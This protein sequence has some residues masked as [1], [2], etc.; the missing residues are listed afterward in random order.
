[1]LV[2]SP[3]GSPLGDV[4][5]T[6]RVLKEGL[7][8][9]PVLSFSVPEELQVLMPLEGAVETAFGRFILKEKKKAGDYY[10]VV[11][12]PDTDSLVADLVTKAYITMT[13]TEM[14]ADLLDG[15]GWTIQSASTEK[16]TVTLNEQTRYEGLLA[17][18]NRF[19][20]E[21]RWDIVNKVVQIEPRIGREN[22]GLY[23]HDQVNMRD[24]S[25]AADSYDL[26]T[27][28]IPRG[29]AGIGIESINGGIPYLEN[30]SYTNK[31]KVA[32][33]PDERY[34]VIENLKADA[35][36]ILDE[37]SKIRQAFQADVSDLAAAYPSIWGVLDFQIGDTVSLVS[38]RAGVDQQQRIIER[39]RY[40]D[41]LDGDSITIANTL[42]DY[43]TDARDD[44][45]SVRTST[46]VTRASLELLD[47]G[48]E[49]R[50]GTVVNDVVED[51][52]SQLSTNIS[53]TAQDIRAEV[54]ETYVTGDTL[55]GYKSEI[56]TQFKQTKDAFT[57]DF[58]TLIETIETVD[59]NTTTKF[60]E[61]NKY[62]RF[63]DG[64][65]VLGEAGNQIT[66]KL[67]NDQI[68]FWQ[69]GAIV[70]V[71]ANNKLTVLDGNFLNVLQIGNFSFRPRSNGSLSFGKVV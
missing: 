7:S 21:T 48:I 31:V 39:V 20:Y 69:S 53:Q 26:I 32:L 56:E 70:A 14:G 11:A 15:T 6:G 28:I 35:Q 66:L 71:F 16:R 2:Y 17:I 22:S 49:A 1:M 33:W 47:E 67:E 45:E 18:A 51:A 3:M 50:V 55:N 25:P 64:D 19:M 65:I 34:T 24:I 37:R 40:L 36:K 62:I 60:N 59:G 29:L 63:I 8:L 68:G 13:V 57:F 10:D 38:V 42:R 30:F 44:L 4:P 43:T 41:E 9:L 58:S 27:R 23:I 54:S 52:T 12:K 61:I 46:S 5:V